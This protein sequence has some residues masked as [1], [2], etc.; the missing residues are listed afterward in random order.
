ME[1]TRLAFGAAIAA[2]LVV[3]LAAIGRTIAVDPSGGGDYTSISA[4]AEVAEAGDIVLV[5]PGTY[6]EEVRV[7]R[8]G[9]FNAPVV[10]K[11]RER[12]KAIVKGSE[13]W[14]NK[15][16]RLSG[17]D[18]CYE[19][20]IDT[21][22]FAGCKNPYLTTI[23]I[24]SS[25]RS[26]AARPVA[27]ERGAWTFAPRTLGQI[28]VDGEP[29]SEAVTLASLRRSPGTWMVSYDGTKVWL[30]PRRSDFSDRAS[31]VEWSVRERV[32][33]AK[34]RGFG[35]VVIDGFTVEHGA[36]QGPFPQ[37]GLIDTRSGT[38]W[39]IENC[40]VRHAK[41]IGV[42]IGGETWAADR[43]VDV[44][45]EDRR[46][47]VAGGNVVRNCEISDCGL[48]GISGWH[49]GR[50]FILNNVLERN[51]SG[52]YG[53]PEKYWGESAAIKLHISKCVV[54]GNVIRDNDAPGI[55]LDTGFKDSRVSGNL[56]VGNRRCGIMMESGV[57][58]MLVDCNI[59]GL[60]K[61]SED[62]FDLGDGIYSHNG[63]RITVAHNL[64][65]GCAGAGIRFRTL[66]GKYMDGK[67]YETTDNVFLGNII[68]QNARGDLVLACTNETSR[69]VVSDFNVYY[70]NDYLAKKAPLYPFRFAN[71]NIG[72]E[73][74]TGLHARVSAA[75]G[76]NAM[77][78]QVWRAM[79]NPATLYE[80][81]TVQGMDRRSWAGA[82]GT[83]EFSSREMS[84]VL[85]SAPE[86]CEM[87]MPAVAGISRDYF[88][89]PYPG[90]DGKT[91]PG[92]FQ[93]DLICS[94]NVVMLSVVP[95]F[96]ETGRSCEGT[97][98]SKEL[99][100]DTAAKAPL[101]G[102]LRK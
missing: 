74:W 14:T 84:L 38:H 39:T 28:F 4:A 69:G 35:H 47:M 46:V 37:I 29:C 7:E 67:T 95:R 15:W 101:V 73:T 97:F 81:R 21:S 2:G 12:G 93:D 60:T 9:R 17:S 63:S 70:G 23:S 96:H 42:A 83:F 50:S 85:S 13:V 91:R 8:G 20:E 49:P 55:W 78:Y 53:W 51:N 72:G 58:P 18:G 27:E 68:N 33:H 52:R 16:L 61:P 87:Q 45:E 100:N 90:A 65:F 10:F 75:A 76:A 41:T 25:D 48:S 30:H 44:P 6:R 32:F 80:W 24:G 22:R 77:P 34:R 56:I 59:I 5:E 62:G 86:V 36:N 102:G 40:T 57:G 43:I 98:P 19:S 1:L 99:G 66:W 82:A 92:P 79:S 64:I 71:Y 31:A 89:N 11:S 26:G 3:P 94:T 54:A 88:G